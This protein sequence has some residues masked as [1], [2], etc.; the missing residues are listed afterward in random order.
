GEN[1]KKCIFF[2][3]G[4]RGDFFIKTCFFGDFQ[5]IFLLCSRHL[6]GLTCMERLCSLTSR[7]AM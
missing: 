4:G 5:S 2:N 6:T 1:S 7:V 3:C